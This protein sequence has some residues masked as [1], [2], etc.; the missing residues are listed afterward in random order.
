LALKEAQDRQQCLTNLSSA[1][2]TPTKKEKNRIRKS[3][4]KQF[5]KYFGM[6]AVCVKLLAENILGKFVLVLCPTQRDTPRLLRWVMDDVGGWHWVCRACTFINQV[7]DSL[8]CS[9]SSFLEM[10]I[11]FFFQY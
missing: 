7:R 4:E 9:L 10:H 11:L 2:A 8:P 3:P 6:Q 1:V 5:K